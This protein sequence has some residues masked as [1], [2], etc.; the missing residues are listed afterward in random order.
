[1]SEYKRNDVD[2]DERDES[3]WSLRSLAP[4]LLATGSSML[5]GYLLGRGSYSRDL[6]EAI[7]KIESSPVPISVRIRD[8]W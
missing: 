6:D 3:P 5:L 2:E 7:R 1:M 4:V 8:V